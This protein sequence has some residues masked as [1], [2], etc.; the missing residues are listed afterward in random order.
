MF[1]F[2]C[3]SIFTIL[4]GYLL[5][6]ELATNKKHENNMKV[7]YLHYIDNES[8]GWRNQPELV[9]YVE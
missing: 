7:V 1:A 4:K 5:Q 3:K 8:K 2:G 6:N 9:G